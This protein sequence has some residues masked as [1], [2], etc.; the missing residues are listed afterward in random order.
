MGYTSPMGKLLDRLILPCSSFQQD[1]L[2]R[3][4]EMK[5][6]KNQH[7]IALEDQ[8]LGHKLTLLDDPDKL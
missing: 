6:C 7:C 3:S 8:I 2:S 1:K 4:L 5:Y